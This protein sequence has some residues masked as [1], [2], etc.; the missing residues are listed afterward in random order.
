MM[1]ALTTVFASDEDVAL[2]APSDFALLC[3][4]DQSLAS[5][6]DG[7]FGAGGGWTLTSGSADFAASGI[8]PGH[9]VQLVGPTTIFRPPGDHLVVSSVA[10]G[11]VVLRRKGQG[12]GVGRP[13]GPTGGAVGVEFLILTLGPQLVSA[14]LDVARRFG[15][16]DRVPGRRPSDLNDPGELRDATVL[17]ALHR[18]YLD[19]AR[20]PADRGDAMAAKAAAIRSEL[21]DSLARLVVHWGPSARADASA[22]RSSARLS[23]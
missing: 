4:R 8:A 21:D 11:A 10:P 22:L 14:S 16:D 12:A 13:P 18:R 15:I 23:R 3:P 20:D 7:A 9:V 19:L 1:T 6:L 2:R 5:G 17:T